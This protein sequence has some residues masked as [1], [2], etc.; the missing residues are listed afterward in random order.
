VVAFDLALLL[1]ANKRHDIYLIPS[2]WVVATSKLSF[3]FYP[4]LGGRGKV[5]RGGRTLTRL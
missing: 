2:I 5:G 4:C 1:L 3:S